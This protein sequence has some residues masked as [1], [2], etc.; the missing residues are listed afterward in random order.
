MG[1]EG[2]IELSAGVSVRVERYRISAGILSGGI[3]NISWSFVLK[4]YKLDQ[5]SLLGEYLFS[6]FFYIKTAFPP[7]RYDAPMVQRPKGL[8]QGGLCAITYK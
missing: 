1:V 5:F 2:N 6:F 7:L 4:G 3:S 8:R